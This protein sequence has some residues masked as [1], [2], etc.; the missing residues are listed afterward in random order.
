MDFRRERSD[1]DIRF[2]RTGGLIHDRFIV[3]DYGTED[4]TIYHSGASEKDAGKK[5]MMI[6]KFEDEI[7]KTVMKNVMERLM[8]NEEL[9]LK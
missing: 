9:K 5:L 7:V 1:V 6:S 3:I 4:E 2:I 8:G